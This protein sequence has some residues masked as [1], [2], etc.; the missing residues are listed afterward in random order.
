MKLY[1]SSTTIML[2]TPRT[3]D[4]HS[5]TH[6]HT[7][8]MDKP[9]TFDSFLPAYIV[10]SSFRPCVTDVNSIYKVYILPASQNYYILHINSL[11]STVLPNRLMMCATAQ[12]SLTMLLNNIISF[13]SID[14]NTFF[15]VKNLEAQFVQPL[16]DLGYPGSRI[17]FGKRL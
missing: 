8:H 1:S 16:M 2:N 10:N 14:T 11:N 4:S 12:K 7:M 3:H 6:S 13:M 5:H 17:L 9:S 15:L